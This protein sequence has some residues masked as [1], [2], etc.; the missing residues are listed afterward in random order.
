MGLAKTL[1][2]ANEKVE[3]LNVDS[4][5]AKDDVIDA[6]RDLAIAKSKINELQ[7]EKRDQARRL[8]DLEARLKGEESALARGEASADPAEVQVLRDI[9]KRQVRVQE[10]RRQA[11]D[12]IVEAVKQLGTKDEQLGSAIELFDGQELQLTP[13]EQKLIAPEQKETLHQWRVDPANWM[14]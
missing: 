5:A 8:T 2:E 13:E 14:R 1:R 11:R 3:R 9:I 6:L 12:V 4:N 10:R 7:Q